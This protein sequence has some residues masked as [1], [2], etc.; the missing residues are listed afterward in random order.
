MIDFK[1]ITVS[2]GDLFLIQPRQVHRFVDSERAKGW[3]LLLK[4]AL[5]DIKPNTFPTDF[6][7][8]LHL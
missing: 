8:S 7:C 4:A 6:N 1:D 3:I 2:Q 5:S